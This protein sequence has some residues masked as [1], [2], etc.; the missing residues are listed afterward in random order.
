MNYFNLISD[1]LTSII[2]SYLRYDDLFNYET[3]NPLIKKKLNW[4]FIHKLNKSIKMWRR[5]NDS[6]K[7]S[8]DEYLS[9]IEPLHME[10]AKYDPPPFFTIQKK[11]YQII[12]TH[13]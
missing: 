1:D 13:L 4:Y 5:P 7:I 11:K 12:K 2:L 3:I 8:Y 6:K 9:L 10:L